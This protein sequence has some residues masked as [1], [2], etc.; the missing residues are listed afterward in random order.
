MG[1]PAIAWPILRGLYLEHDILAVYTQPDKQAGRGQE[2]IY[3]PIKQKAVELGLN[4][5]QPLTLKDSCSHL[6]I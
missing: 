3:S 5:E 4:I 1:T 2:S 6:P